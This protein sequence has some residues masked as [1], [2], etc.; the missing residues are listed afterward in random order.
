MK[1]TL[2]QKKEF[3]FIAA[4]IA[5]SGV[6]GASVAALSSFAGGTGTAAVPVYRYLLLGFLTGTGISSG[7]IS[8]Q[9]YLERRSSRPL[10]FLFLAVP[11]LQTLVIGAVYG[12]LFVLILGFDEFSKNAFLIQTMGFT[13]SITAIVN[14]FTTLNRLL[15]NNVL[16]GL[17]AGTYHTPKNEER[18]VMF[19]DIAGSTSIAEKLGAL[20]FHSFL[21]DFFC[22]ISAPIINCHGEIYKY[23]GDEVIITWKRKPGISTGGALNVFFEIEQALERHRQMYLARYG[24]LP[25]FRAGLHFGAVVAGEIGFH[26]QEIA[27]SGDVMNTAARIQ[28]ECRNAGEKFLVSD[29][30]LSQLAS[31]L[32]STYDI[33]SR[34]SAVLRGKSLEVKISSVR[35]KKEV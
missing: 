21:N 29:E 34:G 8:I 5:G 9:N 27:F 26:K 18:F 28:A 13:F 14:F 23:V 1:L 25:E 30:A 7:F 31:P 12:T 10:W 24:V 11:L 17:F 22:D 2:V 32:L 35:R 20:Q 19:L 15:G 4:L 16:K 33:R 6:V 3:L